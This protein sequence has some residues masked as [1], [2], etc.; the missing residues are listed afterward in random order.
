MEDAK[1][2]TEIT[3]GICGNSLHCCTWISCTCTAPTLV[4]AAD[5]IEAHRAIAYLK[6][7]N[8]GPST[9][10][11]IREVAGNAWQCHSN[12]KCAKFSV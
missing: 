1:L 10:I 2:N 5:K 12:E 9:K 4:P 11:N 7:D 3:E 6:D 8:K